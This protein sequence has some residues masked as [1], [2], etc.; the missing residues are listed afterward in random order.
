MMT[1][2][3]TERARFKEIFGWCMFDFA[4]SAYTTVVITTIF[5][6]YFVGSVV[7]DKTRGDYLWSVALSISYFLV[8]VTGPV[9]GAVADF[10]GWKKR[11][12][13]ISYLVCV[14]FTALLFFVGPGDIG[15]AMVLVVLSNLGF[16]AGENFCASFLPELAPPKDMGKISGYGWSFGYVGGLLSLALCLLLL[17]GTKD[18]AGGYRDGAIRSTN[19]LVAIYFALAAIPTFLWLRERKDREVLA[20]GESYL[21]AG[22][23][24][25]FQTFRAVRRFRELLKFLL[26]FTVYQSGVMTV[27]SFAV[28]Y[29]EQELLFTKGESIVLI[30]VVNITSSV[31]AF[32]F[33][34]IQDRI[35]AKRA[36]L[37]TLLIW[38]AA[39]LGI[40]LFHSRIAFWII[41]NMVG[42]A[43]GSCQS[44]SRALVGLFS[45]QEKSAE[46]FGFW[47]LAGKLASILGIYSF[48]LLAHLTGSRHTALLSVLGFFVAGFLLTL[49]VNEAGGR[50]AVAEWGESRRAGGDAAT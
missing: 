6:A 39:I 35:G 23:K 31:G 45:P 15:L 10:S 2:V 42:V 16:A 12:L 26:A 24:R 25:L 47:G 13:F 29:T 8:I 19:V 38:I 18:A 27:I 49:L 30:I 9:I 17:S 50:S 14:V 33:G 44:A 41:A 40:Y 34:F 32:L 4:N 28:I 36:V 11:F 46:F 5:S 1:K 20:E 7:A 48:G 21:T 22:F 3:A 37:L 43:I